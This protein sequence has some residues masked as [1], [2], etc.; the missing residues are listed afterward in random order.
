[1]MV[2]IWSWLQFQVIKN[3]SR[4]F[5][6]VAVS[7]AWLTM[8]MKIFQQVNIKLTLKTSGLSFFFSFFTQNIGKVFYITRALSSEVQL[9]TLF[10]EL[11]IN[12]NLQFQSQCFYSNIHYCA[13]S[14][15]DRPTINIAQLWD[16][17]LCTM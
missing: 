5:F 16:L 10:H 2:N 9:Q 15:F 13:T 8:Q 12:Y 3:I 4:I 1:M 7:Y 11:L 17:P 14:T 6:L